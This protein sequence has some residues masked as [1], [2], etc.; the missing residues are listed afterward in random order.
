MF[1]SAMTV[2]VAGALVAL[3]GCATKHETVGTLGGGAVGAAATGGSAI[4][5][6][7]GAA[8]GYEAGKIYDEK[9]K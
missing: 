9:H 4:G 3:A 7:G 8:V 5:T 2:V 6:V 1:R